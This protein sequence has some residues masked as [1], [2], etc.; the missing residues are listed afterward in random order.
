[1]RQIR[2]RPTT[3]TLGYSAAAPLTAMDAPPALPA[4]ADSLL[5]LAAQSMFASFA[6]AAMGMLVVDREHRVVW[7]SEGYK[8][9]LLRAMGRRRARVVPAN[10]AS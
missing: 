9:F 8:S 1:M 4:D 2:V 3:T 6:R 10:R 7:I 5:K